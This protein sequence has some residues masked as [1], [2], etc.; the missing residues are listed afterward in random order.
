MPRDVEP[1]DLRATPLLH[2]SEQLAKTKY[3]DAFEHLLMA[4][5]GI[6]NLMVIAEGNSDAKLIDALPPSQPGSPIVIKV[7]NSYLQDSSPV[8]SPDLK[9]DSAIAANP[10]TLNRYTYALDNPL[11]YRD[12][13]G[14]CVSPTVGKGQVGICV[15]AYIQAARLGF[16]GLGI[17]DYRGP[18]AND[19]KATFRIQSLVTVD[20]E[21]GT[22]TQSS[23]AGISYVVFNG[24]DG[25]PGVVSSG[26]TSVFKDDDG[27]LHFELIMTGLNGQ[28][29][30]AGPIG[31][32]AP[33]GLISIQFD[34]MVDP[35]GHVILLDSSKTKTYPS[36]SV[37]SYSPDGDTD[38][39]FQQ[40]ES[41]SSD[42]LQNPMRNIPIQTDSGT[43]LQQVSS[44][45]DQFDAF[46]R[47]TKQCSE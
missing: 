34:F 16:L 4:V 41:K 19:P 24:V 1:Y 21:K 10:Q 26:V 45:L 31:Y 8:M 3:R 22:V 42:D 17:G 38:D 9:K 35:Q 47:A 20:V 2:C 14:K 13:G 25:K 29:V 23:S 32:F 36:I 27:N 6:N 33:Q 39:V 28:A 37:F 40:K 12:A 7:Q 15:E 11:R 18:A 5:M 43:G 46:C 44:S 30:A